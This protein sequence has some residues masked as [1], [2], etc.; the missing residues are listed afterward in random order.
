MYIGYIY[1]GAAQGAVTAVVSQGSR[2]S[3]AFS[4]LL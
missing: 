2:V 3:P 4:L 1:I